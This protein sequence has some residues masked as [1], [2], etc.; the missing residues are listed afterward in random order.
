MKKK[1]GLIFG[2]MVV[3]KYTNQKKGSKERKEGKGNIGFKMF[4]GR[5]TPHQ[6]KAKKSTHSD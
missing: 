4:K 5:N 3:K 6:G 2:N 1:W